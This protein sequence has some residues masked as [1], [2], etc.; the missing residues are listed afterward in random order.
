[1]RIQQRFFAHSHAMRIHQFQSSDMEQ[2]GRGKFNQHL[3]LMAN[4]HADALQ[5]RERGICVKN[6]KNIYREN[7][8][9]RDVELHIP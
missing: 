8:N 4:T 3:S 1:M 9:E 2:I 7:G 5:S 6:T